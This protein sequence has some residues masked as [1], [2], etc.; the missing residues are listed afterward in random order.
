MHTDK[1][2][3]ASWHGT[4]YSQ[5]ASEVPFKINAFELKKNQHYFSR[6]RH[7]Q[8]FLVGGETLNFQ[9]LDCCF[10]SDWRLITG[11]GSGLYTKKNYRSLAEYT[12]ISD[13]CWD[14]IETTLHTFGTCLFSLTWCAEPVSSV[15]F[16]LASNSHNVLC[17][18]PAVY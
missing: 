5:F 10:H 1:F 14:P 6:C 3:F 8:N 18:S 12:S 13:H 2:T 11:N 7:L 4:H 15:I 16:K 17:P 9:T